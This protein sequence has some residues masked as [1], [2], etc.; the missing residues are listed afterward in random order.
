[1]RVCR[2]GKGEGKERREGERK[3]RRR[4]EEGRKEGGKEGSEPTTSSVAF[5]YYSQRRIGHPLKSSKA[6]NSQGPLPI[7]LCRF[8][9]TSFSSPRL[10]KPLFLFLQGLV[11]SADLSVPFPTPPNTPFALPVPPPPSSSEQ[12]QVDTLRTAPR[13]S[14]TNSSNTST[15]SGTLRFTPLIHPDLASPPLPEVGDFDFSREGLSEGGGGL[16]CA[17]T[18]LTTPLG[19]V[20]AANGLLFQH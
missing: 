9:R 20:H 16:P 10:G 1:M 17:V 7:L 11:T 6:E 13:M 3:E 14:S 2:F 15:P 18:E 12:G 5:P 8:F 4:E 19:G